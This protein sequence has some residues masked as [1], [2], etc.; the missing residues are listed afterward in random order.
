MGLTRDIGRRLPGISIQLLLASLTAY[1]CYHAFEGDRGLNAWWRLNHKYEMAQSTL[2]VLKAERADLDAR[3]ALLR[4][5]HLDPDMLEERA[6]ILLN[7]GR[8]DERV[9]LLPK[10]DA[11][12]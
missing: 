10:G 5:D 8:P 6:R 9:I 4:P 2:A 11:A 3:V 1:F 7:F 12:N